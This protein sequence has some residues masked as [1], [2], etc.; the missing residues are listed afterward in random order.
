MSTPEPIRDSRLSSALE[1][2]LRTGDRATLV[3]RLE[4]SSGLPGKPNLAL[5][6]AVGERL[7]AAGATGRELA[8][9]L[10]AMGIAEKRATALFLA[11]VGLAGLAVAAAGQ[12]RPSADAILPIHDAAGDTRHE[13]REAAIMALTHYLERVG[14]AGLV[15]IDGFFD[16][17]LH[18]HVALEAL[19]PRSTLERMRVAES[20][21]G[22]LD[23]AFLL[24]DGATRA[25]DRSQGVRALRLGLPL[26][27][28]AFS[29]R[30]EHEVLVWLEGWLDRAERPESRQVLDETLA[31][32][33]RR[34]LAEPIVDQLRARLGASAPPIR[35]AA[36]VVSGTRKR[37]RGRR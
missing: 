4:R 3:D 2:A 31:A 6:L 15:A 34:Q 35:D 20:L 19:R 8:S 32:L 5:A 33:R 1:E 11:F 37:S 22:L 7:G 36:R 27:I 16:G 24:G 12:K 21:I 25:A 14:D 28:A 9:D 13:I 29:T 17:F 26:Q 30:F 23:R 10:A 18:A